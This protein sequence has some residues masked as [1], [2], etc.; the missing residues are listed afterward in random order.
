MQSP[1]HANPAAV[2][3]AFSV[4]LWISLPAMKSNTLHPGKHIS[5]NLHLPKYQNGEVI[6]RG[7]LKGSLDPLEP[8]KFFPANCLQGCFSPSWVHFRFLTSGWGKKGVWAF[9]RKD[10]EQRENQALSLQPTTIHGPFV[11]EENTALEMP[12]PLHIG[13]VQKWWWADHSRGDGS[14]CPLPPC[15]SVGKKLAPEKFLRAY[16]VFHISYWRRR[17]LLRT[18][19]ALWHMAKGQQEKGT[20]VGWRPKNPHFSKGC[21]VSFSSL[22]S[23]APSTKASQKPHQPCSPNWPTLLSWGGGSRY[24]NISGKQASLGCGPGLQSY[25]QWCMTPAG[26]NHVELGAELQI[27]CL[28]HTNKPLVFGWGETLKFRILP[29]PPKREVEDPAHIWWFG[30]M[31]K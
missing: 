21:G 7:G 17:S 19:A 1:W 28:S 11:F 23:P 18:E 27:R 25:T 31:L 12:C 16:P 26:F 13:S 9:V 6:Y 14:D 24:A 20:R 10:M 5:P 3:V 4:C 8:L 29:F 15:S 2:M 30:N 22:T